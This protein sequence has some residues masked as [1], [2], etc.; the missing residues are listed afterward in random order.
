MSYGWRRIGG[1]RHLVKFWKWL[2]MKRAR[3]KWVALA[4]KN[5]LMPESDKR[6][7]IT[8]SLGIKCP[9]YKVTGTNQS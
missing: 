6:K 7:H 1:I 4:A 5:A 2:K 3:T 8:L 9:E